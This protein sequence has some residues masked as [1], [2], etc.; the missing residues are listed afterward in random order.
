MNGAAGSQMVEVGELAARQLKDY[1]SHQPGMLFAEGCVLDVSQGYELQNAV[2]KLR[3]QRGER[4]IGYKVGCTSSAIQ[5]QLKITHRVRGFLFDT[6]HYE[7]GVALSRQSFDNLAIEGEL[8]IELSREPREEDFAD[9]LLPPCISRIFPVIELHN[10]VMRGQQSSAGE[11][12]ANNAIHAGFVSG[13]G[14]LSSNCFS[15]TMFDEARLVIFRDNQLLDQCEGRLLLETIRSS[16]K[17]LWEE[18]F[19]RGDRLHA[20]QIVLTGSVPN[21]FPVVDECSI[22]VESL[23]FGEVTAEVKGRTHQKR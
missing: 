20:G 1:D 6:E 3:F 8:A 10:H 21:L 23:P 12:I 9:H 2:A 15:E 11:L 17:W 22:R 14:G 5:E 13:G 7:S 19:R 4:L 16:L 18:L